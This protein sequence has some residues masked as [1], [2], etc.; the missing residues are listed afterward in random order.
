VEEDM[1]SMNNNVPSVGS[2]SFSM[3]L[4]T[5]G[6]SDVNSGD[7]NEDDN[8]RRRLQMRPTNDNLNSTSSGPPTV[9][10]IYTVTG[11]C[12]DCPV[13]DGGSFELYDESFRRRYLSDVVATPSP[14]RSGTIFGGLRNL[15]VRT[16]IVSVEDR[17]LEATDDD[18]SDCQCV[19]GTEPTVAQA[20]GVQECV[21]LMNNVF[22]AKRIETAAS[23]RPLYQNIVLTDL[24]QLDD[25]EGELDPGV[26]VD[27]LD[28]DGG[29]G[30]GDTNGD[31]RSPI[32][33]NIW[34]R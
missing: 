21:N 3:D 23:A 27:A 25:L 9:K 16:R 2:V 18:K 6:G 28:L 26:G 13:T 20:P 30:G 10:M 1:D 17:N 11:T 8:E 29:D 15:R 33:D 14:S 19:E 34:G 4:R 7:D 22:E 31:R 12:R 24:V 5:G 32:S